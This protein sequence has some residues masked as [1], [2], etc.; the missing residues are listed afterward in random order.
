MQSY[1]KCD[2]KAVRA[3]TMGGKLTGL[4]IKISL[5][6]LGECIERTGHGC[7]VAV[8]IIQTRDVLGH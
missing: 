2:G 3:L 8:T 7:G 4:A 5:A 6:A 1:L